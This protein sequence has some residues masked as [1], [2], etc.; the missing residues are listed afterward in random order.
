L[1]GHTSN[2]IGDHIANLPGPQELPHHVATLLAETHGL[3]LVPASER[4][5]LIEAAAEVIERDLIPSPL[6]RS[7]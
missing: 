4:E 1:A 6:L 2:T 3:D 5:A 7:N